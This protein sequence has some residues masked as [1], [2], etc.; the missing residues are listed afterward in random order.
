[1][2]EHS[3]YPCKTLVTVTKLALSTTPAKEDNPII[4]QSRHNKEQYCLEA[5]TVAKIIVQREL[6]PITHQSGYNLV[7]RIE[8]V[9]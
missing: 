3:H 2:S 7:T 4:S 9:L 1:M 5:V 8:I 6:Q